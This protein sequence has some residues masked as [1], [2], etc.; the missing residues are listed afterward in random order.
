VGAFVAAQALPE[1]A[2]KSVLSSKRAECEMEGKQEFEEWLPVSDAH[3]S[4]REE[5]RPPTQGLLRG[6]AATPCLMASRVGFERWHD[7]G[8]SL[9]ESCLGGPRHV[10]VP[11]S[12][13]RE[14]AESFRALRCAFGST[15]CDRHPRR[16]SRS[17]E[18]LARRLPGAPACLSDGLRDGLDST[19]VAWLVA[20]TQSSADSG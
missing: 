18:V 5:E 13:A 10:V 19:C 8:W 20:R 4:W 15:H 1:P 12:A 2:R 3:G 11:P 17:T 14:K 7:E 16:V 6:A 9:T